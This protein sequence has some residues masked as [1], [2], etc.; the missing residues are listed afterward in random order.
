MFGIDKKLVNKE[1]RTAERLQKE[2]ARK[3]MHCEM[4]EEI[5]TNCF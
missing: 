5:G 2:E 1:K 4:T 3:R